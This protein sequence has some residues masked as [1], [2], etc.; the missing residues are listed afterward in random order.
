MLKG[1]RKFDP[2]EY[3]DEYQENRVK[4][5]DICARRKYCTRRHNVY[6]I[7]QCKAWSPRITIT[8]AIAA[9]EK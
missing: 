2:I 9:G 6:N 4:L 7:Y 8:R 5:C 3:P 1:I